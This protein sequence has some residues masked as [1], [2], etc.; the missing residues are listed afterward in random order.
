MKT[1]LDFLTANAGLLCFTTAW[2]IATVMVAVTAYNRGW[3]HCC[4]AFARRALD[5]TRRQTS[6]RQ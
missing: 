1:F 4:E 6:I 3:E 2:I 5:E